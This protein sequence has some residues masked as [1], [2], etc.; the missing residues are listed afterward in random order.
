ME[1]EGSDETHDSLRSSQG[2]GGGQPLVVDSVCGWA[3]DAGFASAAGGYIKTHVMLT[4]EERT[5]LLEGQPVTKLLEADPAREVAVFGA[6][7][8]KAPMSRYIAAVKDIEK[9]EKGSN[10][11]V[12]KR[13]SDPPRL[14]DFDQLTLPAGGRRGLKT[15]KVGDMRAEAERSR[16]GAHSERNRLVEAN[17]HADVEELFR[18][19][20][21]RV[22]Q[23][24]S[25]GRKCPAGNLS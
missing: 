23:W 12:T 1:T 11:L 20:G 5:Q 19:S 25:G 7:W 24:V 6:V 13:I 21:A 16:T 22:R 3:A 2:S 4:P 9:F 18:K 10:F 17:C 8:V 15:C 14:E